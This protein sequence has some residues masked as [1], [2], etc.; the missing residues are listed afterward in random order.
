MN[1]S[2]IFSK[3]YEIFAVFVSGLISFFFYRQ[4]KLNDSIDTIDSRV[5]KIE[6]NQAT[7]NKSVDYLCSRFDRIE[8]S[9]D[10]IIAKL[11]RK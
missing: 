11:D 8:N 6:V 2:S 10:V 4:K 7:Y 5:D 3:I 9:I 1:E